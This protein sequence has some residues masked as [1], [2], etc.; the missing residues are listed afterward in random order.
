M[1]TGE[2]LRD[3][4]LAASV[5]SGSWARSVL[6]R[7]SP[8]H[9]VAVRQ[10]W[11]GGVIGLA[12]RS[13]AF[14]SRFAPGKVRASS[15]ASLVLW[16]MPV[17]TGRE[18]HDRRRELGDR[19]GVM[20]CLAQHLAI[21]QAELRRRVLE[22]GNAFR[23]EQRAAPAPTLGNGDRDTRL[24]FHRCDRGLDLG[25]HALETGLIRVTEVD[26]QPD[27]LGDDAGQIGKAIDARRRRA[28]LLLPQRR[29][30]CR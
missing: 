20:T 4:S 24:G 9:A 16:L 28:P 17:A 7:S 14:S 12:R 25:V 18:D 6:I 26:D 19:V 23:R 27:L 3:L 1:S 8:M 30:Q 29:G 13:A 5:W 11:T 21:G 10:L 2:T 22:Q 15:M